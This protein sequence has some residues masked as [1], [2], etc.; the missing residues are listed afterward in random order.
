MIMKRMVGLLVGPA[1]AGTFEDTTDEP[2]AD[3]HDGRSFCKRSTLQQNVRRRARD[4]EE[5]PAPFASMM[6]RMGASAPRMI[7]TVVIMAGMFIACGRRTRPTDVVVDAG[8]YDATSLETA[9]PVGRRATRDE[10]S[11]ACQ[12]GVKLRCFDDPSPLPMVPKVPFTAP[13]PTDLV[14]LKSRLLKQLAKGPG[15]GAED[16]ER[17]K[18]NRDDLRSCEEDCVERWSY[19]QASCVANADDVRKALVCLNGIVRSDE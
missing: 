5:E 16:L 12:I 7:G 6:L 18:N 3:R 17:C 8:V 2:G 10:C 14:D 1:A 11:F 15:D 19:A 9:V 4:T 13:W